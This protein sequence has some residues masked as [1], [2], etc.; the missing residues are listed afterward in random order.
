L[1]VDWSDKRFLALPKDG[2]FYNATLDNVLLLKGD[3]VGEFYKQTS[4]TIMEDYLKIANMQK[5]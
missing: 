5:N 3:E 1:D 2:N 4:K